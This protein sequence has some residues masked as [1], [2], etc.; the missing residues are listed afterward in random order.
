[1][2]EDKLYNFLVLAYI[3][4]PVEMAEEQRAELIKYFENQIAPEK[5]SVIKEIVKIVLTNFNLTD[6]NARH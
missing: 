4:P 1:M 5:T 6:K 3:K 2:T